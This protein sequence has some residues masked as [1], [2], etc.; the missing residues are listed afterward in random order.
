V[1]VCECVFVSVCVYVCVCICV[2]KF[3]L[4][5]RLGWGGGLRVCVWMDLGV[6]RM[7]CGVSGFKQKIMGV[8]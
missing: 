2:R 5:V 8:V 3:V 1:C 6:V 7:G 4:C